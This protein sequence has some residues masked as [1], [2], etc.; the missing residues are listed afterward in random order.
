MNDFMPLDGWDHLH[1]WVGNARQATYY[2]ERAYGFT[3]I[4]YMGPETGTRDRAS[5]V[6]AQGDVRLVVTSALAAGH[7]VA[8]FCN[9]HGDGVKDVALTVPDASAAYE[10]ALERGARGVTEPYTVEDDD[11]EVEIATIAT[12]GDAVHSFVA[13]RGYGGVFL[14][15]Y[16]ATGAEPAPGSG[17]LQIDHVVGNVEL[18][19]MD[20]WVHFYERVLGFTELIHFSDE[21]IS[22]EYSALMSKVMTD[23]EGKI[24]FPINEP[25]EGKRKSQIEEY[26]EF[27]DGPGVQHVAI[28]CETSSRR[29]ARSG[30]AGCASSRRPAPTTRRRPSAWATSTPTG[31]TSSGS[32]SWPTGTRRATSCR[33]SRVRCRI[34]RRSS[35]R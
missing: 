27:Y 3:P 34:G 6:L 19:A 21:A 12:Y 17:L 22:T 8:Q 10:A 16:R 13:R 15:G 4:A 33:S 18:G 20:E 23:G 26:L 14:P 28:L 7:E 9:R 31:P 1:L 11:G 25:A 5:Y 29:S 24:K 30:S 35:S 2:Y 32:G